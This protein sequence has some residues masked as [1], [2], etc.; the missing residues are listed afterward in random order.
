M[1]DTIGPGGDVRLL[2][3]LLA[4]KAYLDEVSTYAK[5]HG[6]ADLSMQLWRHGALVCAAGKRIMELKEE[7]ERA[8]SR[9]K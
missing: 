8:E 5:I 2:Q 7:L 3:S 9:A 1:S 6:H 4:V